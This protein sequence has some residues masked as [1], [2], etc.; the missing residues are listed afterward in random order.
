MTMIFPANEVAWYQLKRSAAGKGAE[1]FQGALNA[2][3]G[4]AKRHI[5]HLICFS[6]APRGSLRQLNGGHDSLIEMV[7]NA[8]MN[9]AHQF[10]A[11]LIHHGIL[12]LFF[13]FFSFF[14]SS[15][16]THMTH[17][18]QPNFTNSGNY[19]P[20]SSFKNK[21]KDKQSTNEQCQ[22]RELKREPHQCSLSPVHHPG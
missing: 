7:V 11:F 5:I 1:S 22:F 18:R 9:L 6:A 12:F 13:S 15:N 4:F 10:R 8:K 17:P 16:W 21:W 19:T 14:H 3:T 2:H 20:Q